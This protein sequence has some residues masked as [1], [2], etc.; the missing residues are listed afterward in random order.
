MGNVRFWEKACKLEA[1]HCACS[2]IFK[3]DRH[4]DFQSFEFK[5]VI[6]CITSL[7]FFSVYSE[8]TN[9]IYHLFKSHSW[10]NSINLMRHMTFRK[11]VLLETSKDW[12][13]ETCFLTGAS[14]LRTCGS[15][16]TGERKVKWGHLSLPWVWLVIPLTC[17]KC[18]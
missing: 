7:Y 5:D 10:L 16:F 17:F 14:F 8:T 11:G 2:L 13:R 12:K 3:Y 9:S 1:I 18:K 4:G 15:P 6:I